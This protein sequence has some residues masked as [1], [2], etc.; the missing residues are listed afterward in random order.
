MAA[1]QYQHH[2]DQQRLEIPL[3][4]PRRKP[5]TVFVTIEPNQDPELH[6]VTLLGHLNDPMIT[7]GFPVFNAAV[8]C[9]TSRTYALF[10]GWV[11]IYK[12]PGEDWAMDSYPLFHDLKTPYTVWGAEPTLVDTPSRDPMP[13]KYDWTARSFLCYAP[14]ACMTKHVVPILAVEW[15]FW[16]ED[17]QKYVK[18]LHRLDVSRWNE[19][20]GMFRGKFPEWTFD[21]ATV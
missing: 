12:D 3:S 18:K 9:P 6:G 20:T 19:H 5:G 15:G 16:I 7:K 2:P 4:V 8:S 1:P 14:D 21:D 17:Y 13:E 10:Y 11:Q